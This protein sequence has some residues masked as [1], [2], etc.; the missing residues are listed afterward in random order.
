M[1]LQPYIMFN[2]NAREAMNFY[3]TALG[4]EITFVQTYG[5]APADYPQD[6]E[7]ANRIMHANIKWEGFELMISDSHPARTVT[8]GEAI[9]ISIAPDS[10]EAGQKIFDALAVNGKIDMPYALQ[11]WG[12]TFGSLTDKFGVS[13]MV[14]AE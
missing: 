11:F 9:N 7:T 3:A 6:S 14:N 10:R 13:W 2:G 1:K 12:A 8:F 5:E 4:G